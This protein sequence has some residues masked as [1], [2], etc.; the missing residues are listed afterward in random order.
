MGKMDT[1]KNTPFS[2]NDIAFLA[3]N[4]AEY[5]QYYSLAKLYIDKEDY[6]N[7]IINITNYETSTGV[8]CQI[9]ICLLRTLM[10]LPTNQVKEPSDIVSKTKIGKRVLTNYRMFIQAVNIQDYEQAEK[11]LAVCIKL[12]DINNY[13]FDLSYLMKLVLRIKTMF[14]R[15]KRKEE[16]MS[17]KS[18]VMTSKNL[19]RNYILLKKLNELEPDNVDTLILLVAILIVFENY[20]EAQ[21]YV[22]IALKLRPDNVRLQHNLA[23]INEKNKTASDFI[24]ETRIDNQID[25]FLAEGKNQRAIKIA[26]QAFEDTG[27]YDFIYRIG[28]IL[29]TMQE[30]QQAKNFFMKYVNSDKHIYLKQVYYYLFYI[31]RLLGEDNDEV[32]KQVYA[33]S[34]F[35]GIVI[36]YQHFIDTLNKDWHFTDRMIDSIEK[37]LYVQEQSKAPEKTIGT[38]KGE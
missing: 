1:I 32:L 25:S 22:N 9:Y 12:L 23:I 2:E 4:R 14:E 18:Y 30:Y 8:D 5:Y 11:H 10:G 6:S 36:T 27:N 33:L 21:Y 20:V 26:I 17:L 3:A 13:R 15:D 34:S 37:E 38:L 35:D 7:A 16:I 28:I 24:Q 29:Y 19:G 31:N